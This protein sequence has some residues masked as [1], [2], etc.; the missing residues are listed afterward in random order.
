MTLRE[1]AELLLGAFAEAD[2]NDDGLLDWSEATA[3]VAEMSHA[4]FDT[5][6]SGGDHYLSR[7][8]LRSALGAAVGCPCNVESTRKGLKENLGELFLLGVSIASLG[9]VSRSGYFSGR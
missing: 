3:V 7:N 4:T 8:E 6:D 2:G 9:L 1:V 5:L